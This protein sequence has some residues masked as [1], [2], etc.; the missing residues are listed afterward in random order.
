VTV[1]LAITG[2][3][4]TNATDSM[5]AFST[6]PTC[7]LASLMSETP[8]NP[9]LDRQVSLLHVCPSTCTIYDG[10]CL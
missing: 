1:S 6:D 9:T 4:C 7:P 8:V 10:A 2:L 5:V 3:L